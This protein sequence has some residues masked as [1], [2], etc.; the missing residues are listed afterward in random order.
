MVYCDASGK[1]HQGGKNEKANQVWILTEPIEY[2]LHRASIKRYVLKDEIGDDLHPIESGIMYVDLKKL[3]KK[4]YPAGE[5]A[6][7][8][9]GHDRRLK[10]SMV[11]KTV[12]MIK[13]SFRK[14]KD[15]KEG[16]SMLTALEKAA[17]EGEARGEAKK[18]EEMAKKLKEL[19]QLGLDGNE[20]VRILTEAL[21]VPS[22]PVRL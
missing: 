12:R 5:L 10:Y 20:I 14:F 1:K 16:S 15:E 17:E 13:K 3:A 22:K 8:L 7:F 11:R 18:T 6:S 2:L 21:T 9:L 19:K 4:N